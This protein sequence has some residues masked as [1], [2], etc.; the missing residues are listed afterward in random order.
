MKRNCKDVVAYIKSNPKNHQH[1]FLELQRCC[2]IDGVLDT[3][4]MDAH[5]KYASLG[6]NGGRRCDVKRGPCSCGAW[7]LW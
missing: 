6:T 2:V 1:D 5:E 4:I 7:H 3:R